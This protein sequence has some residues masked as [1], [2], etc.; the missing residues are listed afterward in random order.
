MNKLITNSKILLLTG[1]GASK[2]LGKYLMSEFIDFV[3][4]GGSKTTWLSRNISLSEREKIENIISDLAN[5]VGGEDLEEILSLLSAIKITGE[6]LEKTPWSENYS[7]I[8][9]PTFVE[10]NDT[11]INSNIQNDLLSFATEGI[12]NYFKL[13][14]SVY[15]LLIENIIIHYSEVEK[16]KSIKLYKPLLDILIPLKSSPNIL[17]IFTTNYDS[18]IEL[19]SESDGIEVFF[20][21]ESYSTK[22]CINPDLYESYEPPP[23]KRNIVLFH[24]HGSVNW[25]EKD[26]K[27][28]YLSTVV[29][30]KYRDDYIHKI[31][32]PLRDK[33]FEDKFF[34]LAYDYF[35]RC[36]EKAKVLIV[37]GYSFRD[38][39]LYRRICSAMNFNSELKIL[40]LDI[41][42]DDLK[43]LHFSAFKDRVITLEETFPKDI[44]EINSYL[45][46]NL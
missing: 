30:N 36:L 28:E 27:I 23:D 16:Q 19:L 6:H 13:N 2:P 9:I 11:G 32:F 35:L 12:N 5:F 25:I 10:G 17:P 7:S 22:I 26:N 43:S 8:E 40:I 34:D 20:A 41:V 38:K 39:D 31:I 21:R 46:K 18:A 24:L 33:A 45:D 44:D 4:K 37:I 42:A 15:Q 1:A 3:K 29:P 14:T